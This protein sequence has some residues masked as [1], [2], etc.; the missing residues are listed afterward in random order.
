MPPRRD[1]GAHKTLDR[2]FYVSI[3]LKGLNA[4]LE[5]VG[6][7]G[8]Y[9]ATPDFIMHVVAVA[10]QHEIAQDPNDLVA[11]AL[12]NA[13]RKISVSSEHFAALYFLSHGVVKIFLVIGLLRD[14]RWAYPAA[15]AVF[16]AFI[17][18]QVYRFTL[19]HGLGLVALTVFDLVVMWLIWREYR[20]REFA[21]RP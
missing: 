17:V 4:A 16:G 8:L 3:W 6:G 9:L 13:V 19:P 2:F 20:L 15:L 12:L 5:I 11:N 21:P 10:T 18:Y 14:R 7:I 1:T